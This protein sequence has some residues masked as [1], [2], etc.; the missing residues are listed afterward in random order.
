MSYAVR[1]YPEGIHMIARFF[2]KLH[3]D[4]AVVCRIQILLRDKGAGYSAE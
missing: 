1:A 3:I 2:V 4:Y